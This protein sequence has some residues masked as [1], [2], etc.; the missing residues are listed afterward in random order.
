M[1]VPITEQKYSLGTLVRLKP[2][3]GVLGSYHVP[4]NFGVVTKIR[5][6]LEEDVV[7]VTFFSIS[8]EQIIKDAST[9]ELI[10]LS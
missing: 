5:N 10:L 1:N 2:H 9:K 4:T 6:T 3:F 7:E 8:G